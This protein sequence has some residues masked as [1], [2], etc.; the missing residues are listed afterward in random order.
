MELT[1]K[2]QRLLNYLREKIEAAGASPSLRQAAA[3]L[4]VS[5]AAVA[6]TMKLLEEKGVVRREGRYG[7]TIHL[8][9]RS[10]RTAGV[11]RFRE[12][13]VIGRITAGLPMYAQQEW[14]ES[15]VVDAG[16]YK[17]PNIFAL[18]V[19]GD[20]MTGAGI[21]HGDLAICRPQQF[22]TDGEIVAALISGEE[23]TVKR[24]FLRA[25][26]VLLK[27]EN[28]DYEPMHCSFDQVLVQ[29]RVIGLQ[30]GPEVMQR[31]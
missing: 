1:S 22:A 2:Q 25:D 13:P 26:H 19:R 4:G 16:L 10:G 3:D 31:L 27:P 9:N 5:H 15:I 11:Q 8:L 28:P 7:R 18:R 29:G 24:F 14:E 12:V 17:G 20:S 23:A 30:R 21:L 6:R